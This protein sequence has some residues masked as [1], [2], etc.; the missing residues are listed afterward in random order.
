MAVTFAGLPVWLQ[1]EAHGAAAVDTRCCIVA[2]TVTAPVVDSTGLCLGGRQEMVT[3]YGAGGVPNSKIM[4]S[5][6]A[7]REGLSCLPVL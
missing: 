6:E 1:H 5:T 7:Q 4:E 3:S 2:L